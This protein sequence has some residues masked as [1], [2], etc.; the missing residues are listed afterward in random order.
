M[1]QVHGKLVMGHRQ[2]DMCDEMIDVVL[3]GMAQLICPCIAM[4]VLG[5][6]LIGSARSMGVSCFMWPVVLDDFHSVNSAFIGIL[7]VLWTGVWHFRIQAGQAALPVLV[8]Q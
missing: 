8:L 3:E 6:K 2:A 1:P 7:A 4:N 5:V